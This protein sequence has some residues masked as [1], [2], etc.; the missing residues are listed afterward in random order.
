MTFAGTHVEH[1][2]RLESGRRIFTDTIHVKPIAFERGGSLRPITS[3]LGNSGDPDLS[4]G[5]DELLQF[6]IRDRLSGNAP[7]LHVGHGPD[8]VRMTPLDTANV[9][10]V[11]Q[12][13][14]IAFFGAWPGADLAYELGGHVVRES[15]LLRMGHP[16]TFSFR[17][18][19]HSGFDPVALTVGNLRI[20]QPVLEPPA[21]S[22]LM[23]IPLQWLVTQQGG[24]WILS[25]TLPPGDWA[26]WTFDPTLTLQPD[27]TDGKDVGIF[28]S[29]QSENIG[30]NV[31][32][33]VGELNNDER[34]DRS[35]IAFDLS[36]LSGNAIISS[37][38]LSLYANTAYSSNART[39][40]VYRQKRVW[41]EG[42][43]AGNSGANWLTYNGVN[44][45]QTAGG[46]GSD[47]CEQ[48]DIGY[49]DMTSTETLNEFKNW[50]LTPTTKTG[51]DL[52]NGWMMKADTEL[53]DNYHFASSDHATAANRP[54]LV[55]EYT[56]PGGNSGRRALLGVGR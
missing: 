29:Q 48:T 39:F 10:A 56:L 22:A 6:R 44:A 32:I 55:V 18:D 21:G 34:T 17:I 46:F 8:M 19:A 37:A 11:V 5:C 23:A 31:Q 47:D 53:N 33:T 28:S 43:G 26:G 41:T 25:V 38:V 13:N 7:V 52:G 45:W 15:I 42:S 9:N 20:Q 36:S 35:L 1:D 54:K 27:A 16:R 12:G 40:R 2:E 30:D 4:I 3:L 14:R 24:K 49:R 51:L 50:P